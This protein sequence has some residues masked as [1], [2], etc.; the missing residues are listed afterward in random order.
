LSSFP[1]DAVPDVHDAGAVDS[2]WHGEDAHIGANLIGNPGVLDPDPDGGTPAGWHTDWWG[3][4]DAGFSW[5][6]KTGGGRAVRTEVSDYQSGDAKWMF[7]RVQLKPGSWYEYSDL[8]LSDGRSRLYW[9]CLDPSTSGISYDSAWQSDKADEWAQTAFRFY[10]PAKGQCMGTV[11]HIVDRDGWLETTSHSLYEAKEWPLARPLASVCFD[12]ISK[13]AVTI[14]A[15][16][17]EKRGMK[18]SFYIVTTWL[19]REGGDYISSGDVRTL[20]EAGHE[21]GS[22]SAHHALMTTLTD[23]DLRLEMTKSKYILDSLGVYPTGLAYPY[24]DFDNRVQIAA[25]EVYGYMRTSLQGMNDASVDKR[26]LRIVSISSETSTEYLLSQVDDA[27]ATSSWVIFLFHKLADTVPPD[28]PYV[29]ATAQ[30]KA[31]LD[32]LQKG[33]ITVK[34]IADS[35]AEM[36]K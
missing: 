21:I 14:G 10:V 24:G 32:R 22:H 3:D 8:H 35:L 16:E 13:T 25:S 15:P 2:S 33:D 19:D 18:G 11:M 5:V 27:V 17:L 28:D 29:T 6:D 31:F 23:A 36:G 1:P 30:Y 12:D 9:S 4:L 7:D 34:T 26:K 20:Y